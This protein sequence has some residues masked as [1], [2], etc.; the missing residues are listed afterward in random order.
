MEKRNILGGIGC[1][2]RLGVTDKDRSTLTRMDDGTGGLDSQN[3]DGSSTA[4]RSSY[5]NHKISGRPLMVS[6]PSIRSLGNVT[7]D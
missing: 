3:H 5:C 2:W 7:V 6:I 1:I 4:V